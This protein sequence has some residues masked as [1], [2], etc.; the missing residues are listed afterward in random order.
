MQEQDELLSTEQMAKLLGVSPNTL[1]VWRCT[2][3]YALP[4]I[5]IGRNVR[6]RKSVGVQFLEKNTVER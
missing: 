3:R 6:Y 1:E 4:Y 5:K 2:K